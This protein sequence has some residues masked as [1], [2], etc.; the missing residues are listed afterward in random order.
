MLDDTKLRLLD[1]AGQ[2]FADKGFEAASVREIC[3]RAEANIA[4]VH[5]HFGDKQQLYVAAV[6]TAQC[7]QSDHI[8][9]P[10]FTPDQPATERLRE[11]IGTM[12]RRMLDRDRPKW[13]LQLM[14]RELSHPTDT[15]E[16]IVRDYIRPL[17][18]TLKSILAD[19]LPP[20]IDELTRWRIGF[21]IIGQVL[22][23]YIH[24]PVV[25]LLIGPEAYEDM[26]IDVLTDHVT[27]FSLAAIGHGSPLP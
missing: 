25:Q 6:R 20:E 1:A 16:T 11:F 21:S 17:A 26:T 15:C 18:A 19:L 5:Y 24:R 27:R 10:E 13:H 23:H 2:I 8:P 4:A 7:A 12:F 22:F 9:F 3:Q 14:L